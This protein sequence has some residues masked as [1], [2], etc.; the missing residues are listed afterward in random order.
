MS[1]D[2]S[3]LIFTVSRSLAQTLSHILLRPQTESK[4]STFERHPQRLIQDLIDHYPS[5]FTEEAIKAQEENSN[6]RSI[7]VG[8]S[9]SSSIDSFDSSP[10]RRTRHLA[11]HL[12]SSS[13]TLFEDPDEV[14]SE[15]TM[16]STPPNYSMKEDLAEELASLDSFFLDDD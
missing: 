13:S 14:T 3:F 16:N 7:I 10:K 1:P 15:S 6:R 2:C 8:D 9:S 5:I 11:G 4:V 12:I